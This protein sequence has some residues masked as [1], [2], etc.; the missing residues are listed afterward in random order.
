MAIGANI[1]HNSFFVTKG[2]ISNEEQQHIWESLCNRNCC[3]VFKKIQSQRNIGDDLGPL[4][5]AWINFTPD[6]GK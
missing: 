5:L 6:M 1:V 2:L 3:I 4:L